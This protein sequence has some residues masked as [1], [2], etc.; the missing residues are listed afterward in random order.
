MLYIVCILFQRWNSLVRDSFGLARWRTGQRLAVTRV[1]W[2]IVRLRCRSPLAV[3]RRSVRVVADGG[4]AVVRHSLDGVI[5]ELGSAA[6]QR[7]ATHAL[8]LVVPIGPSPAVGGVVLPG[9]VRLVH[10]RFRDGAD[11]IGGVRRRRLDER[12]Q[13]TRTAMVAPRNGVF[14]RFRVDGGLRAAVTGVIVQGGRWCQHSDDDVPF[15]RFEDAFEADVAADAL[16]IFGDDG[17]GQ[18]RAQRRFRRD[19]LVP[20][21]TVFDGQHRRRVRIVPNRRV[22]HPDQHVPIHR[23]PAPSLL[24]PFAIRLLVPVAHV[25]QSAPWRRV[26]ADPDVPL[27]SCTSCPLR[28]R[29][30]DSVPVGVLARLSGFVH[31]RILPDADVPFRCSYYRW[32]TFPRLPGH[33]AG[34]TR[35]GINWRILADA[36]VPI[37]CSYYRWCTFPRLSGHFA[38]T[39]RCGID[40]RILTDA[41]VPIRWRLRF[42]CNRIEIANDSWYIID[43]ESFRWLIF[44]CENDLLVKW[45]C[46]SYKK[47]R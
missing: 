6:G 31:G 30:G 34:T 15:R 8:R 35:C 41:H 11:V 9:L 4:H 44:C 16:E 12:S 17:L 20:L 29:L 32:C 40:R 27:R 5:G 28:V 25:A 38:G 21:L 18:H 42:G 39:T 37:R 46:F 7:R 45:W 1:F 14:G 33:F 23:L 19:D 24:I 2:N 3:G 47:C 13:D 26:L 22:Q 36:H 10:R 43:N